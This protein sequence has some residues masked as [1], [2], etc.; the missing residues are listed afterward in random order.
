MF[1]TLR[2]GSSKDQMTD[3][4]RVTYS[5]GDAYRSTLRASQKIE[6]FKAKGVYDGL[7]IPHP[8]FKR[9]ILNVAVGQSKN[10]SRH[11]GCTCTV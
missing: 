4:F 6:P 10:L 1:P 7:K 5:I 11:S 8:A 3:T 9:E 2:K